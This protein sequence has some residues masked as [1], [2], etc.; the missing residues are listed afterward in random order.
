MNI[1]KI[2]LM[3]LTATLALV[4]L[5]SFTAVASA[6]TIYVPDDYSMIQQAVNAATAGDTII[7]KDGTYNENV[8]LNKRL[9]IQSANGADSTTVI[10]SNA[11]DHVFNVTAN[12]V[13]ISGFTVEGAT[14]SEKAGIHINLTNHC[15]IS[16]NSASNN[17]NGIRLDGSSNNTFTNNTAY[18]NNFCGIILDYSSNNTLDG[19][20]ASNNYNGIYLRYSSNNTFVE[21]MMSDNDYILGVF[22]VYSLSEYTHNIDTS[23]KVNGKPVY[24]WV[25][26]Q[27]QKI[28]NDAGYV[29]L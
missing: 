21:N 13:N 26:R 4:F 11:D 3:V 14:G 27:D 6:A 28:P 23:N 12:Y 7:V 5:S 29:G 22:S 15:G 9:T 16:N 19:N 25:G 17:R 1:R 8:D 24:Y 10:A 18:S 2:G 20:N